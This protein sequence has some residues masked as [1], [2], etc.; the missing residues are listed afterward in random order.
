MCTLAV[1]VC[2]YASR[3]IA[4]RQTNNE[5]RHTVGLCEGREGK[6]YKSKEAS[7]C[8]D[9]KR[10]NKQMDA[11]RQRQTECDDDGERDKRR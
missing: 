7:R 9:V 4:A 5:K 10:R 2:I 3:K 11:E 8:F 1:C 6:E